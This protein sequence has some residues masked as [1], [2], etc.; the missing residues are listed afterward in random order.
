MD[1]F[2]LV[3]EVI[4]QPKDNGLGGDRRFKERVEGASQDC[5]IADPGD[6]GQ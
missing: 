3:L 4:P 1:E 5:L 6:A 2:K